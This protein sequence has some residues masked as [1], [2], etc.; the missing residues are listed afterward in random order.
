MH[1]EVKGRL[2]TWLCD[3]T[4]G[5]FPGKHAFSLGDFTESIDILET[6]AILYKH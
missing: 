4:K 5:S 6:Q 3:I 2:T 1:G